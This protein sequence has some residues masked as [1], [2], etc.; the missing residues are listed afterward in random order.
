LNIALCVGP[1]AAAFWHWR[2]QHTLT[3][4][5]SPAIVALTAPQLHRPL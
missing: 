1:P 2:H 4:T 3:A 5:G